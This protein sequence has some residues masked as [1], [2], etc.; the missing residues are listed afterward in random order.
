M[1]NIVITGCSSGIG[2]ETAKYLRDKFI[3]VYPT[4]RKKKDV[5]RLKEMGFENAM[6]L[7]VTKPESITAVINTVLIKEGTID[8]WFNNAGYGQ[9]GV[10][11]DIHT[12]VLRE[13]FETNVFG[14]HECIR[15][16]IPIMREQGHGKVIQH[17]S[18]LGL[19]SLF[20]RGAYNASKY[21][22]EGLS[23]TLRLELAG[24]DIH[25]VLLNTG[26][27]TSNFRKNAMQ[28]LRENVN[29][30]HSIF[31]KKY[32]KN[33]KA[34]KSEVPFNKDADAVARMVHHIILSDKPE[35]R[36]YITKA[37]YLLGY[38]KRILSTT[39]LDRILLKLG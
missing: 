4:A 28:K 35:P 33:L 15:Q 23:D 11:E 38:L 27:I 18:V 17:S 20:G 21:A 14:L 7:D 9:P 25:V 5:K 26:P 8:T 39:L 2:L 1:S 24:T 22:V 10:I 29:I 19:V 36:Y 37:T 3:A 32:E 34:K 16:I 30:E 6:Q 12:D 31:R 13:Q